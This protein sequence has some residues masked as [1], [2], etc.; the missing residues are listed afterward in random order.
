MPIFAALYRTKEMG[1]LESIL[2]AVSLCADCFAVALCS[3]VTLK[4]I[5]WKDA[6]KVALAFALIQTALL[7]AGWLFGSLFAGMVRTVSHVIGCALLLYVGGSMLLEGIRGGGE[8]RNLNGMKNI[9]IGGVATSIDAL[10]IGVA[11]SM[12][13]AGKGGTIVPLAVS[14]AAVTMIS[15]IAGIL[16]GRA[17]GRKCGS[18]AEIA[19]GLVLIGIGISFLF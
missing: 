2:T 6:G 9:I 5:D 10:A 1:I 18:V 16:G 12:G 8:E 3:S 15:V 11:Q 19:G 14:V 17:I 4:K 7:L 13:E